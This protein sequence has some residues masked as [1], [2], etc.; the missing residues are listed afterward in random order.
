[1]VDARASLFPSR[2]LTR[3]NSTGLTFRDRCA[4]RDRQAPEGEG[5]LPRSSLTHWFSFV[6]N[7]FILGWQTG[8]EN[9]LLQ[10]AEAFI[11]FCLFWTHSISVRTLDLC[12]YFLGLLYPAPPHRHVTDGSCRGHDQ[13]NRSFLIK[14]GTGY[15][16]TFRLFNRKTE[17]FM[18]SMIFRSLNGRTWIAYLRW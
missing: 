14:R 13:C 7:Y 12:N 5:P 9:K 2:S 17:A 11:F 15:R 3:A 6:F 18:Q 10:T 1:M 4:K 16:D 8:Q